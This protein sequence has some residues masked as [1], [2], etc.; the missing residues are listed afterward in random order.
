VEEG[1]EQVQ[2]SAG[3]ATGPIEAKPGK[4]L[5]YRLGGEQYGL[6]IMKVQEIIGL[7]PMTRVPRTPE[8]VRGVINLRGKVIPIVDLRVKFGLE[9]RE[10]TRK[11]CIV[12]MQILM[13]DHTTVSLGVVVDEVAEVVE[14]SAEQLQPQPS[15]G[16]KVD[17]NI[18]LGI[19]RIGERIVMLLDADRLVTADEIAVVD[20]VS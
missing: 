20:A 3:H 15:V 19:G 9:Q 2:S 12:V 1:M 18:I 8:C 17:M 16:A 7:M 14:F 13:P 11:T 10:D 6:E 4:Y 5:T